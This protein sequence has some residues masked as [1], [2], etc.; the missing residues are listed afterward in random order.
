MLPPIAG[1]ILLAVLGLIATI[2]IRNY[3][4]EGNAMFVAVIYAA[5]ILGLAIAFFWFVTRE[6]EVMTTFDYVMRDIKLYGTSAL[7]MF[8]M[9]GFMWFGMRNDEKPE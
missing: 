3:L 4:G 9:S 6:P 7:V 1:M 2:P 5:G 8:G